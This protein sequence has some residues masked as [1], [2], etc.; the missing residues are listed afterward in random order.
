MI[1]SAEVQYT[2]EG[3]ELDLR[4]DGRSR[5]DFRQTSLEVG[6]IEQASGSSRFQLGATDVLVAVKAEVGEPTKE[7]PDC[8]RVN[9]QV[10]ISACASPEFEGRGSE[11]L[12][13]ELA[14]AL[15]RSIAEG[16]NGSGALDF[17]ALGIMPG[18]KCWL[19]HVDGIV[20]NHDGSL[21][22]ALSMATRAALADT[23][24][25]SVKLLQDS[26]DAEPEIEVDDEESVSLDVSNFP[27]SLTVS[28]FGRHCALDCT[29]TE[30]KCADAALQVAVNKLG[31]VMG[32]ARIGPLGIEPGSLMQMLDVAQRVAP[33]V[34]HNHD[35]ILIQDEM[36][37]A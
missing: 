4:S 9:V 31:Q 17:K 7:R 10:D 1:S 5:E 3:V 21:L 24:L 19:L 20:L 27:I 18:R 36:E 37:D 13:S 2:F 33:E 16:A 25:P 26:E 6:V 11:E 8:G 12:G 34:I 14:A 28:K 15:T 32:C 29:K 22:D 35:S 23:Q 30:E